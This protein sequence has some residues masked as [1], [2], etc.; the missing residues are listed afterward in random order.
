MVRLLTL[1]M[2][3]PVFCMGYSGIYSYHIDLSS[4]NLAA[5]FPNI[6]Q[7]SGPATAFATVQ[8][9]NYSNSPIEVNCFSLTKPTV[10]SASSFYLDPYMAMTSETPPQ[11][12]KPVGKV[13]WARSISGTI[14]AGT[15]TITGLGY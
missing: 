15:L 14:S 10:N 3:V 11:I 12:S 6:A 7:L 4:T 1:I 9:Q 5:T 2:L 8:I 13:C